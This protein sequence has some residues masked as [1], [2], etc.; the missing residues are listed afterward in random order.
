MEHKQDRSSTRPIKLP[1][2][3][4]SSYSEEMTVRT[5]G[6]GAFKAGAAGA[7]A[8]ALLMLISLSD[9]PLLPCLVIPGIILVLIANGML[10][11][12]LANE[13]LNSP[14]QARQAGLLAGL[15][16]GLGA[17]F[18]AILLAAFGLLFTN[19]GEGV[20]AQ[21]TPGQLQNLAEM[22]ISPQT[23]RIAGAIFFA[24]IIWG[25]FGTIIAAALGVLGAQLYY[26]LR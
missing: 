17:A 22:G 12:L 25:V 10:A 23:V 21:F 16:A 5:L 3:P 7:F 9:I 19:L 13:R 26:R 15:I 24:L 14:R 2:R 1:P 8:M 4:A 20:R 6:A 11:G 18:V